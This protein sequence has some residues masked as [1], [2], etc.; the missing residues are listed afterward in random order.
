MSGAKKLTL[1]SLDP[2]TGQCNSELIG[3]GSFV[4][5]Y[6]CLVFSKNN[7]EFLYAGT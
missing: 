5:D 4:R 7:E 1:W 2:S 3:T 6:T